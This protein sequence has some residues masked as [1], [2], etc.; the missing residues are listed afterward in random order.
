LRSD[1]EVS[2]F[3][4]HSNHRSNAAGSVSARSTKRKRVGDFFSTRQIEPNCQRRQE[5]G[6]C[7]SV[8]DH[9]TAERG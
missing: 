1:Q 6:G 7:A 8:F 3:D 5:I 2:R 4:A 9:P